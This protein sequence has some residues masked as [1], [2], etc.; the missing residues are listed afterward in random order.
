MRINAK[1][2]C[3]M[4][5]KQVLKKSSIFSEL[6]PFELLKVTE[7]CRRR[8]VSK[9]GVVISE[10]DD[11]LPNSALYIVVTGLVK[12]TAP[13]GGGK[14]LVLSF[15]S[16][17]DHFGEM[18]MLD[19]RPRSA[20]VVAMEDTELLMMSHDAIENLLADEKDM[21]LKFYRATAKVLAQKLRT[22]NDKIVERH[23]PRPQED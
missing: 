5:P 16:P 21:S 3:T 19:H 14:E 15:L 22:A 9:G 12:V 18:S 11:L 7:I 23:T 1:E 13:L 2:G 17:H 6:T 20:N 8:F 4:D 10:G